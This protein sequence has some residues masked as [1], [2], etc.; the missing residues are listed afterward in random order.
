MVEENDSL[1]KSGP[2]PDVLKIDV[3]FEAAVRWSVSTPIPP[4]GLPKPRIR[5]RFSP[6][7]KDNE[8]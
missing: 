1:N 2:V 4:G 7:D 6:K 3:P 8:R 5:P